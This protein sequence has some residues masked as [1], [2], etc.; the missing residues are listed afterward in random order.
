MALRAELAAI[1]ATRSLC[2]W[3]PAFD[4]ADCCVTPVLRPEEVREHPLF[5]ESAG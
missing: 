4:A 1:I 2:E 5:A 3:L